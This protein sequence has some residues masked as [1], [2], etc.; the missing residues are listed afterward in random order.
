[1]DPSLFTNTNESLHA[2]LAWNIVRDICA[3]DRSCNT[4][5]F[6]CESTIQSEFACQLSRLCWVHPSGTE[7]F[8]NG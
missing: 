1:M 3:I 2:L 6:P 7:Q 8:Q 5:E 4:R